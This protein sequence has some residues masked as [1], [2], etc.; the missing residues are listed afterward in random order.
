M[1]YAEINKNCFIFPLL[2]DETY[3]KSK[4][5]DDVIEAT[6]PSRLLYV[7]C[8]KTEDFFKV[9]FL[10]WIMVNMVVWN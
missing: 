3:D 2:S 6:N 1:K 8:I 10:Y 4:K 5:L 7:I 9:L